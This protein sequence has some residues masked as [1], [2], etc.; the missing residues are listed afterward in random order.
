[1]V[2]VIH[3]KKKFIFDVEDKHQGLY[4]DYIDIGKSSID[5]NPGDYKTF[6]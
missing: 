1:M 6:P 2:E 4:F 5:I 3:N